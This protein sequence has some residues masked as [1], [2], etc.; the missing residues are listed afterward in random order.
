MKKNIMDHSLIFIALTLL[1][2]LCFPIMAASNGALSK[3]IGSPFSAS[4]GVFILS[5]VIMTIVSVAT[6][7]PVLSPQNM[8]HT[9]FSMWLGACI[10]VINVVTFTIVPP[11]IGIG[12]MIV[13]FVTGQMI[14]SVVVEHFGLLHFPV[15]LFNWQR[16]IGLALIIAGVVLVKKF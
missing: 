13:L 12:N 1:V 6:K 11:K 3:S 5:A 4:M 14:A 8:S 15:H 7:S 2:G 16:A 10:V 9:H